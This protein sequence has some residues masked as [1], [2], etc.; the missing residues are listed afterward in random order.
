MWQTDFYT[1]T[2]G[3]SPVIE[4]IRDLQKIEKAKITNCI[5]LL[6]NHG[7]NLHEPHSK[8]LSGYKNLFELRTSGNSPIRLIYY[9]VGQKYIIL[10]GFIKK[11]NK[12]PRKEIQT[13]LNRIS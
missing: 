8:K 5:D 11:T 7:P 4:F 12:T 6:T 3:K 1:S 10:H 2:S 13:A 9:Q